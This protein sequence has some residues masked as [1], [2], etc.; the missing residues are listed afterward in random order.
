M[1]SV[2]EA[3][4]H[5]SSHGHV[6]GAAAFIDD[7]PPRCDELFVGFVGSPAASGQIKSIELG[8]AIRLPGVAAIYTAADLPGDNRYG[9]IYRDEPILADEEVLYV[10]QPVVIVAAESRETLE[11]ARRL[12]KIHITPREPIL[13]IA[14]AM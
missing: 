6:T 11:Q 12:V 1:P 4:P 10:G 7:L 5:D 8:E 3:I 13:S 2:G 9:L 14:R